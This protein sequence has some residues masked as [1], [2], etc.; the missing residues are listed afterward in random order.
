MAETKLSK[1]SSDSVRS[2][3]N[4]TIEKHLNTNDFDVNVSSGANADDNF[5]GIVQRITYNKIAD[6]N[7]DAQKS[8]LFLKTA[9]TNAIRREGFNSRNCFLREIYVYDE[10]VF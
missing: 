10:V 4:E 2:I 9:P 3:L 6:K 5:L 8:T 7:E 1:I